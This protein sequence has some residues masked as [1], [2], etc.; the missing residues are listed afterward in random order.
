MRP[1][2]FISMGY[3]RIKYTPRH[4]RTPQDT[5]GRPNIHLSACSFGKNMLVYTKENIIDPK[6]MNY[7]LYIIKV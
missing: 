2:Y 4:T 3:L 6:Y 1:H 5:P 7:H